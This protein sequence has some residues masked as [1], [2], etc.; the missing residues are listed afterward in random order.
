MPMR[1][2]GPGSRSPSRAAEDQQGA[3][4]VHLARM[5]DLEIGMVLRGGVEKGHH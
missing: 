5:V 2:P 1:W 4:G 3:K